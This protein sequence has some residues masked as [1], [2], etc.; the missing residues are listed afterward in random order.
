MGE[1]LSNKQFKRMMAEC[2]HL[3]IESAVDQHGMST[4]ICRTCQRE[5]TGSMIVGRNYA[6]D[7][8]CN[9][10]VC[11]S[12]ISQDPL[13]VWEHWCVDYTDAK[14]VDTPL[15]MQFCPK[16]GKEKPAEALR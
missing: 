11:S 14:I 15:W 12:D 4:A 10:W 2:E 6:Y 8:G 16:C 5:M 1:K 3:A 7:P 9:A 13:G